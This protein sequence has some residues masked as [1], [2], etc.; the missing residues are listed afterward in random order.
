MDQPHTID[1]HEAEQATRFLSVDRN[2][3]YQPRLP[4]DPNFRDLYLPSFP[5]DV[6]TCDSWPLLVHIPSH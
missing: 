2:Q 6:M 5:R 3:Q 1:F 4:I